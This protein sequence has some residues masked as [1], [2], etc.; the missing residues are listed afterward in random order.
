MRG[1]G[2][3]GGTSGGEFVKVRQE[4]EKEKPSNYTTVRVWKTVKGFPPLQRKGDVEGEEASS[5]ARVTTR[6]GASPRSVKFSP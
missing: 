6:L 5:K 3:Y 2:I 4:I 1:E